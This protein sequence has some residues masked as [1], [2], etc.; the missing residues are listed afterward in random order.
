[1]KLSGE[2]LA[3]AAGFASEAL[4]GRFTCV[5]CGGTAWAVGR[6]PLPGRRASLFALCRTCSADPDW[7]KI[8]SAVRREVIRESMSRTT[9]N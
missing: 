9:A 1:V 4:S 8:E 6:V 2:E 5:T 7:A 3:R